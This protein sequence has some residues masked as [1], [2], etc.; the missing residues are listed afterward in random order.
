MEVAAD[1]NAG[2]H[3]RLECAE[4]GIGV[5]DPARIRHPSVVVRTIIDGGT[6]FG[7]VDGRELIAVALLETHQQFGERRGDH[8]PVKVGARVALNLPQ[9]EGQG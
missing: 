9:G 6:I 8:R 2:I 1:V 4:M 3:G 7:D 5:L